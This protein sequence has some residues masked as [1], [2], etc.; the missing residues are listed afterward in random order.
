[1]AWEAINIDSESENL[2][3]RFV[4]WHWHSVLTILS[5]NLISTYASIMIATK[6]KIIFKVHSSTDTGKI[7]FILS[8]IDYELPNK[9]NFVSLFSGVCSH[10]PASLILIGDGSSRVNFASLP[11]FNAYIWN[12]RCITTGIHLPLSV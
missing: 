1:M 12:I 6:P 10:I 4:L 11:H 9:R 2:S 5:L 7:L 8:V 3:T